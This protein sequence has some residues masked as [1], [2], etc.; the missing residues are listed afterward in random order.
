MSK[1][2]NDQP[3]NK[4]DRQIELVRDQIRDLDCF[5]HANGSTPDQ[6]EQARVR[7]KIRAGR[8]LRFAGGRGFTKSDLG[9][10]TKLRELVRAIEKRS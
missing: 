5:Y 8:I 9:S 7:A 2:P 6:R 1:K 10:L 3:T 4:V